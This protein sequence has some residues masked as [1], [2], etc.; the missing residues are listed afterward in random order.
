MAL[1][2]D[3]RFLITHTFPPNIEDKKRLSKFLSKII[4][5]KIYIPSIVVV[6]YIK[7]AGKRIGRISAEMKV[8]AWINSGVKIISLTSQT[9]FEAGKLALK[10]PNIPIA[11][12][13]IAALAQKLRAKVVTNDPHFKEIGIRT[14]WYT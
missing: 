10:N 14:T 11:D 8:K 4:D 13:I 12:I 3:T 7:V 2:F 1:I 6:E 5:K 9:A